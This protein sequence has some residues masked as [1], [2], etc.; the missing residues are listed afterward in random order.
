MIVKRQVFEDTVVDVSDSE[1]ED[2]NKQKVGYGQTIPSQ[3][4]YLKDPPKV[5]P[6]LAHI[7]LNKTKPIEPYV[8]PI[9]QH[10]TI[11]HLYMYGAKDDSDIIVTGITER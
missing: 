7:L 1:E 3:D 10:V 4:E 11:N 8:L 2:E 6:H 5:P 9:P